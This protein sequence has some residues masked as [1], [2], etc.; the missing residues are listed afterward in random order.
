LSAYG[1]DLADLIADMTKAGLTE[2]RDVRRENLIDYFVRLG[3]PGGLGVRSRARRLSAVRGWF[4]FLETENLISASPAHGLETP[5]KPRSLPK[6]LDREDVLKILTSPKTDT[7]LGLRN[8]TMF[9]T[10]YAA[11]LRVTEL[12]T[13]TL[14]QV[15]LTDAFLIVR[16]KGSKERLVPLGEPAVGLLERWLAEGRPG[17]VGP[18]SGSHVFLNR[19][20]GSL[21]RQ[22]FWKLVSDE[23]AAAGLANVS[24][25]VL[26]HSFATHLVAGGADL[27][28]VQMM[29][30]HASLDTT[31]IYL[32]VEG[33]RLK[34]TH[35]RHHPRSGA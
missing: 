18:G 22:W 23:A 35:D 8:R 28:S 13:L 24:P 11:G 5:R 3:R 33:G 2:P 29:L 10:V 31:E 27:R 17:L 1:R 30:G 9:E 21:S 34:E 4:S 19:R 26:R 32:K 7:V 15:N 12:I 14:S 20:G 25:H 6:A 16:G